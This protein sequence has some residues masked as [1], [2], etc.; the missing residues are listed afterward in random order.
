MVWVVNAQ[1]DPNNLAV[2]V[3]THVVA[4]DPAGV[5]NAVTSGWQTSMDY[6]DRAYQAADTFLNALQTAADDVLVFIDTNLD[7]LDLNIDQFDDLLG[8]MP[9][10]P[11]NTFAFTEIPYSSNLLTDT[12]AVLLQW[13]DGVSTGLLPSVE[14]AI[15]DRGRGR[16]TTNSNRKSKEAI[17]NFAMRGFSKPPGALST[18]LLDAVQEA[19]NANSTFSRDVMI[20]Q[21]DLEQS[22]RR[23]SLEQAAKMEQAMIEYTNQQMNRALDMAKAIQQFAIEIFGH[24]VQAYGVETQAYAA[25]VQAE[26]AAFKAK[27][28]EQVAE[29]N[30]RVE[31]SRIQLQTWIQ[32]LTLKVEVAKAGAQVTAQLAASALSAISMHGS[33]GTS[34]SNGAQNTSGFAARVSA[35]ESVNM[36]VNY[37]YSGSAT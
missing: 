2:E 37:Q 26:T 36:G 4:E 7:M 28:D 5:G 19:Q 21:A 15:W 23:F 20:K 30:I 25:R 27:V 29:A 17:R 16:E 24:E 3:P 11:E 12:R 13:V 31:A 8:T 18:E 32:Q 10:N 22:N 6:A 1:T 14:Q 9:A 34:V 33:M 35:Q